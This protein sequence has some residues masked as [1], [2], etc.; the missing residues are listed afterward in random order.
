MFLADGLRPFCIS[1]NV[2][3]VRENNFNTTVDKTL[4]PFIKY[5]TGKIDTSYGAGYCDWMQILDPTSGTNMWMPPSTYAMGIM[6][7][8]TNAN[9]YW[10]VPAGIN[11][12]KFNNPAYYTL[13]KVKDIAFSPTTEEAGDI[14]TK[15]WN[16]ATSYWDE[17]FV[18]EGQ[19]TFQS[20]ATAFD[21]INV[22]RLFLYLER[23]TYMA[24]RYFIYKGNTA[25]TRQLLIDTIKPY[26]EHAKLFEGLY[27]YRIVC[28]ETNNTADT[29]DRN[30]LHVKI[31]IKPTKAIEFIECT[32]V[33]LRTGAS[34]TEAGMND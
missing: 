18:L 27:D 22:R 13:N 10:T 16:Y 15:S 33:A 8:T 20:R 3:R 2:K 31:A 30:E 32:F 24:A 1:G 19:R 29:I 21:R 7:D 17:G 34:F 4:T 26:F 12:G 6:L 25:A 14:Y 23:K 5:M 28:D 9:Y 11:Y